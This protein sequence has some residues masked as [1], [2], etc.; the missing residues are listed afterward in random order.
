MLDVK[1]IWAKRCNGRGTT[2]FDTCLKSLD[3]VEFYNSLFVQIRHFEESL[4]LVIIY[5]YRGV[6]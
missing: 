4:V 6:T 1:I 2:T 5:G 3:L